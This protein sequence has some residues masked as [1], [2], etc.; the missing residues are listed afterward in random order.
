[1]LREELIAAQEFCS[2]NQV[3][4]SFVQSLSEA[5]LVEVTTVE[6]TIYI[7][8]EQLPELEKLARFH[9]DMDINL[10]GIEAIYH[11]LEQIKTM[12]DEMQALKRRLRIYEQVD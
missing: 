11:L 3:E 7:N 6:G 8:R 2:S 10:E 12:Q 5:G 9:Y 1:M 4:I